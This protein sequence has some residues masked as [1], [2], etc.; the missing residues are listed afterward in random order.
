MKAVNVVPPGQSGFISLPTFLAVTAGAQSS[1]GPNFSDQLPLYAN[2]RYKPFQF[3]KTGSGINPGGNTGVTI[4]R[5]S[6][7]VPQIYADNEKDLDYGLGYAMAQDRMF[8]MDIFRHVGH[9]TL[10]ELIGSS[11]LPLD[12]LVRRVSEGPQART[13]ELDAAPTS[14]QDRARAFSDGITQAMHEQCPGMVM[15]NPAP[16]CPAE[17]TLLATAVNNHIPDWTPDDTL[18]FGE[19]AG[20]FFGEFGHTE[21]QAAKVYLDMVARLGQPAAER[22]FHD[23]YALQDPAAP[24]IIDPADGTFPRHSASGNTTITYSAFANADATLLPSP[25]S[26]AHVLPQIDALELGAREM[27]HHLGIPTHLG[28]NAMAISGRRTADGNPILYS[29]PQTGWA[30][31]GFF[32]EFEAHDPDRD[33]R[34]VT[35]PAIPLVVIGRDQDSGWSVTSALDGNSDTF[36]DQLD[37]TDTSYVHNGQQVTIQ[38]HTE[39]INCYN[40]PATALVLP[41]L[42]GKAPQPC[43]SSP[44]HETVYYDPAHDA[45]GLA[46]PDSQHLLYARASSVNHHFVDTIMAWDA[47]SRQHTAAGVGQALQGLYLAFNFFYVDAQGEVAYYRTGRYPLRPANVDPNLP[48]WGDGRFDWQGYE[49]WADTPHVV[50]PTTGFVVNWNNKPARDWYSKATVSSVLAPDRWGPHHHVEPLAADVRKLDGLTFDRAGQVPEDVAYTDSRARALLPFLLPVLQQSGDS[51]LHQVA[52]ALAAWDMQR[53]DEGGGKLHTAPTFFDRWVEHM[54]GDTFGPALG[55]SDLAALEGLHCTT[56]YCSPTTGSHYVS[57]DN[58][59]APTMKYELAI[60][61]ALFNALAGRNAYDFFGGAGRDATILKAANDVVA[62]LTAAQGGNPSN[63]SEP[64]E[65]GHFN[66][67]GA[68]SVPDLVPLPNRGSYGQVI[69]PLAAASLGIATTPTS[70]AAPPALP[71]TGPLP[72]RDDL[73]LLLLIGV[74]AGAARA[75]RRRSAR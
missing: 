67:Q 45:A 12:E 23:L 64:L 71:N 9:G 8:Q 60:L 70:Q 72:R 73:A 46:D 25:D 29:G 51:R 58:G 59:D 2:W 57:V 68:G 39:T 38:K 41:L 54:L 75:L 10:A 47:L 19:Y 63:W 28:S 14:I 7:G 69:E 49:S 40:P 32:W 53:V 30:V 11:G 37:P 27:A 50:N 22:A 44:V 34:G 31:P 6:Y 56:A 42:S 4:H 24:T 55:G 16:S 15:P 17:Y 48:L 66:A 20:R 1:F 43:P 36:L 35:V 18:S 65:T 26:L 33:A 74:A 3:E 61:H 21:L 13:A 5:D 62:E 52:Q